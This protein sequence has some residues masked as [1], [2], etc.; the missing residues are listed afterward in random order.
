MKWFQLSLALFQLGCA[1]YL[2]W[3]GWQLHKLSKAARESM[4]DRQKA[5]EAA[6]AKAEGR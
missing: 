2:T 1:I 6:I 3:L 5:I 4:A